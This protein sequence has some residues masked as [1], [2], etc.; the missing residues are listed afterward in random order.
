MESA[1][2][3]TRDQAA[4]QEIAFDWATVCGFS[5]LL[6]E[7]QKKGSW[8]AQRFGYAEKCVADH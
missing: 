4:T 8:L 3:G 2:Y 7:M 6:T 1:D 5:G